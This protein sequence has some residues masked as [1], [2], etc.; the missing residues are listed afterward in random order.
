MI[1]D[2]LFYYK[3]ITKLEYNAISFPQTFDLYC[4]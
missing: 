3:K 1:K 2:M 4:Y